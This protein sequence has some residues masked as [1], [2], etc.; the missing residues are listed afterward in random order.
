MEERGSGPIE[1]SLNVVLHVVQT[2]NTSP[3]KAPE[4]VLVVTISN[5]KR[6][7]L[8]EASGC[9][10]LMGVILFYL[11]YWH[12]SHFGGLQLDAPWSIGTIMHSWRCPL[13]CEPFGEWGLD[14]RLWTH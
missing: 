13:A 6:P 11:V 1:D 7:S 4:L 3:G 2:V 9:F 12:A 10:G 14:S 5:V 8:E